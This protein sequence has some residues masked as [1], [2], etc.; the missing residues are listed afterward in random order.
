MEHTTV[1]FGDLPFF[2]FF[3]FFPFS[4]FPCPLAL[5]SST[6]VQGKKVQV[7]DFEE[8]LKAIDQ[9]KCALR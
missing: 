9:L 7:P 2:I 8:G 1:H 6:T 3:F 5:T 4:Q